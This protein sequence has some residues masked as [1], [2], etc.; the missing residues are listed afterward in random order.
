MPFELCEILPYPYWLLQAYLGMFIP[1]GTS[2]HQ[3]ADSEKTLYAK[4][5]L[6]SSVSGY[7]I[8]PRH[9]DPANAFLFVA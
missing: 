7:V 1:I 5:A 9:L 3:V 6:S 8:L 4:S 2:Q